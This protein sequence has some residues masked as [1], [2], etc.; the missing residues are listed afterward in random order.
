MVDPPEEPVEEA[1]V[2]VAVD[3]LEGQEPTPVPSK[4]SVRSSVILKGFRCLFFSV[5]SFYNHHKNKENKGSSPLM[6]KDCLDVASIPRFV[7]LRNTRRNSSA[8]WA[9][10]ST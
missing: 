10:E 7:A 2:A 1:P 5:S 6:T 9:L 3:D 4:I 8:F